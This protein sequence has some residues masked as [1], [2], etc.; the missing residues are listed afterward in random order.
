MNI[1]FG[2]INENNLL[3]ALTKSGNCWWKTA[4]K[5]QSTKTEEE[6]RKEEILM[7]KSFLFYF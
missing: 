7:E 3:L 4:I 6:G 2:V 5:A 1:L